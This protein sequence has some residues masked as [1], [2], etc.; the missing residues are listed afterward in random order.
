MRRGIAANVAAEWRRVLANRGAFGLFILAPVIYGVFYPQPYRTQILRD[1]PIA[2]VD[3]DLN[4][5]SREIVEALDASGSVKVAVRTDTLEEA[6]RSLDRGKVFAIVGI[7]PDTQRDVLKGNAVPLPVYVDATYLFLYKSAAAGIA[8]AIGSVVSGLA[9]GGARTD[10]SLA[11][12]ALASTS[13]ADILLQPIFNPVGGYASYV[14]PAAF[15]LIVQ[16]T[17]LI[18]SAML[19]GPALDVAGAR[20]LATVLGRAFA[21]LTLAIP[22]LLLYLIVLP[23]MYGL[24]ALGQ[25]GE[26]FVLAAPFI[27]ATSLLGQA[28]GARF[29]NAET[30]VLLF[31]GLSIPLFFLVGFAW[32]REAIPGSVLAA[33]SIFPSEFAID[34]LVR[35]NQTG[36]GLHEVAPRLGWTLVS[37]RRVLRACSPVGTLS[38]QGCAWLAGLVFGC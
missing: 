6:R 37:H 15:I 3:N 17:L 30:P 1:V 26:L 4:G 33:G 36:A 11:K 14:V 19:T 24:P 2:V 34:G 9:A 8:D 10:G 27:L 25:P 28:V 31:L 29:R 20:P 21:H 12:A 7:P 35:L 32:P 13:P 5:F 22:A 16:Q 23:R 38:T 18:G